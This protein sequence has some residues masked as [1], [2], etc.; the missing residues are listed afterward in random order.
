MDPNRSMADDVESNT[1][2]PAQGTA[3]EESRH[4]THGQDEAREAFLRMMSD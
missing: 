1:P 4:E 2:V 3:H